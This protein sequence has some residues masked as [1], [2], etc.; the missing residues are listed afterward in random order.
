M[1]YFSQLDLLKFFSDWAVSLDESDAKL[2][3]QGYTVIHGAGISYLTPLDPPEAER[4]ERSKMGVT[5]SPWLS[6]MRYAR[7]AFAAVP[8]TIGIFQT[9]TLQFFKRV[10]AERAH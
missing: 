10:T 4:G 6:S 1:K 9:I 7:T 5:A 3:A 2:R 8:I